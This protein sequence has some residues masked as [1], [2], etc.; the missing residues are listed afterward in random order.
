MLSTFMMLGVNRR[1][2]DLADNYPAVVD[3]V[4]R[5]RPAAKDKY[6]KSGDSCRQH[7]TEVQ[8]S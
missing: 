8:T 2:G 3:G 7:E 5:A 1:G 6:L 4:L